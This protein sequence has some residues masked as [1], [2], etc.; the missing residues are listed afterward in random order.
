MLSTLFF[1][2]IFFFLCNFDTT[3]FYNAYNSKELIIEQ[4]G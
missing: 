1:F 2:K 3:V 4:K